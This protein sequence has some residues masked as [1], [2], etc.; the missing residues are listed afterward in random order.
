LWLL[1]DLKQGADAAYIDVR[2]EATTFKS[3]S[4]RKAVDYIAAKAA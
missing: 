4:R 1:W 3:C 2:K